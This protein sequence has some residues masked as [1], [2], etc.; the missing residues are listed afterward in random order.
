MH[1]GYR[2]F[3][4]IHEFRVSEKMKGP[5]SDSFWD[6]SPNISGSKVKRIP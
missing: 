6:K 4:G 2:K 1:L 5:L 3:V